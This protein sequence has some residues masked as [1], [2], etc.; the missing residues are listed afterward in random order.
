MELPD[1]AIEEGQQDLV[2]GVPM[3]MFEGEQFW[4]NDRTWLLRKR[5]ASHA[6]TES[7]SGH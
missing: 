2:S 7:E 4:G 1:L 6:I 3:F 5:L